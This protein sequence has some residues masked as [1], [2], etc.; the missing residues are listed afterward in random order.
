MRKLLASLY[1]YIVGQFGRL[2][3]GRQRKHAPRDIL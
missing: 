2:M 3:N 1:I